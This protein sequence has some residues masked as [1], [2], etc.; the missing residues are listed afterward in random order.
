VALETWIA[1]L[2][3]FFFGGLSPGPAVMLVTGSAAR[4]GFRPAMVAGVGIA[5]ANWLWL[6]LAASGAALLATR[7]PQ[8]F[9]VLKLF[10]L[11][12]ILW[13]GIAQMRAPTDSFSKRLESAPPRAKLFVSGLGLQLS[14][15]MALVTFAGII[16]GFFDASRP[17]W[18]QYITMV[19]TITWLELQ[20]LAVYAGFGHWVRAKLADPA[21]ARL[22]N[23]ITGAALILAGLIAVLSTL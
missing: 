19:A 11:G 4:Y 8:G 3:L 7:F 1:L 5:L 16:P 17:I 9:T 14:N 21:K 6:A 20:G 18:P 15:P 23:L 22:F 12:V 10:G 2:V 13:L